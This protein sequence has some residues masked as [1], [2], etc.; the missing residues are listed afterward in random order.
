[1]LQVSQA[2]II[3]IHCVWF[4]NETL[5]TTVFQGVKSASDGTKNVPHSFLMSLV[6]LRISFD[7]ALT[8]A[9][10]RYVSAHL[11]TEIATCSPFS[12]CFVQ[13]KSI[14][15]QRDKDF[16][17]YKKDPS[18]ILNPD[19]TF[20]GLWDLWESL[21]KTNS[22]ILHTGRALLVVKIM[23]NPWP[24]NNR[25]VAISKYYRMNKSHY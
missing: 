16:K 10:W 8:W 25:P 2:D 13:S 20:E 1:M 7:Y 12:L 19:P 4:W 18:K 15:Q 23:T 11:F 24:Q 17:S 21:A 3:T 9:W 6:F 5:A 22:N 14:S